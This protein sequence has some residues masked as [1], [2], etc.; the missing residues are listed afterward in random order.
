[1]WLPLIDWILY[2]I[3][4]HI[5]QAV[6]PS[7]HRTAANQV[8]A[9]LRRRILCGELP[10]GAHLRQEAVAEMFGVSRIPVR[11]ALQRLD[12]EGWVTFAPHRG[13]F[14]AGLSIDEVAELF[15]LR[16]LLEP[17]LLERAVPRFQADS[18]ALLREAADGFERALAGS[19]RTGW[20]AANRAFHRQL[21]AP[22][23][24]PRIARLAQGFD[25]RVEA[26]VGA[27]L[28][29]DGIAPRAIAEH[30]RLVAAVEARDTAGAV[31]V[32]RDHLQQTRDELTGWIAEREEA[33]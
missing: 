20:G 1:M 18:L 7:I 2:P 12:A 11:E 19:D 22:A 14:V 4:D 24:R 9:E 13:A 17:H 26:Y 33:A 28:A 27:H 23:G 31:R 16:L 10:A 3:P 32:L 15:E 30:R 21:Y 5:F 6:M 29:L 8:V 25:E